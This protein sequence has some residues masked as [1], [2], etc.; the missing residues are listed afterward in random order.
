MRGQFYYQINRESSSLSG[1]EVQRIKMVRYLNSSL[2]DLM[3]I[4]DEP[5]IGLHLRDVHKLNNL[6]IKLRD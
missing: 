5:S 2:T 6:L 1:G 4:F 3:Y